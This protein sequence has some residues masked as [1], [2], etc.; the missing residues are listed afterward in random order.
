MNWGVLGAKMA[1]VVG[2]L[3]YGGA[4]A[5]ATGQVPIN[6]KYAWVVAVVGGA[7][8]TMTDSNAVSEPKV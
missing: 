2:A 4:V 8:R 3:L 1:Q 6:A 5:V 7:L